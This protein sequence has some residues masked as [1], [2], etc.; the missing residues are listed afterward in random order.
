MPAKKNVGQ[1]VVHVPANY[2][3]HIIFNGFD[4]VICQNYFMDIYEL[5]ECIRFD[6][7]QAIAA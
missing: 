2:F 1:I 3:T 6:F 5:A 4:L 7:V